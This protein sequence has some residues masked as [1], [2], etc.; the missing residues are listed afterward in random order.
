MLMMSD[1]EWEDPKSDEEVFQ[2]YRIDRLKE[3]QR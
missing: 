2:K 3:L 1:E